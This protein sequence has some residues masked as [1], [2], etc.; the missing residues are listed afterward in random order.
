MGFSALNGRPCFSCLVGLAE[1]VEKDGWTDRPT[2]VTVVV[3][4]FSAQPDT[5]EFERKP[6]ASLETVSDI[7][8]LNLKLRFGVNHRAHSHLPQL[9]PQ[10]QEE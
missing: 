4:G 10:G 1:L 8:A 2:K 3:R 9:S 6:N 5:P 7:V